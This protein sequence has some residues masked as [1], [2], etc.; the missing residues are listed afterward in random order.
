MV[1]SRWRFYLPGGGWDYQAFLIVALVAQTVT[2]SGRRALGTRPGR[3]A[4]AVA[5]QPQIAIPLWFTKL[6]TDADFASIP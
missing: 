2:E 5:R 1:D 4:T 6:S 3:L